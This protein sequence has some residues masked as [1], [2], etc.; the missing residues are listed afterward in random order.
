MKSKH[1]IGECRQENC[2]ESKHVNLSGEIN[3][4]CFGNI[5][6]VPVFSQTGPFSLFS[7]C[8][9]DPDNI[10]NIKIF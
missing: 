2:L 8:S 4:L 7:L 1:I 6:K 5:S 10:K 3:S 9:G